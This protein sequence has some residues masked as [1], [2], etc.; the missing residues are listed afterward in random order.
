MLDGI[1]LEQGDL[2]A[3]CVRV[4]AGELRVV[5]TWTDYP[6]ELGASPSLVNDLDLTVRCGWATKQVMPLTPSPQTS[7][8]HAALQWCGG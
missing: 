5:L 2:A 8:R 1:P 6:A 3:F 7:G 4:A